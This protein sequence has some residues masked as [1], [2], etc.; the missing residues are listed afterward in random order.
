VFQLFALG[1]GDR[2]EGTPGRDA[3]VE[4]IQQRALASGMLVGTYERPDG[5]IKVGETAAVVRSVPPV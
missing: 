1:P 3:V 4:A 5:T 2:F